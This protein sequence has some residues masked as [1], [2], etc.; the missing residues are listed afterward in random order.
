MRA[1]SFGLEVQVNANTV[2]GGSG[3]TDI[4]I[5]ILAGGVFHSLTQ[6]AFTLHTYNT[7]I[8]MGVT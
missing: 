2:S 1:P 5:Y 8:S 6:S 4:Y 7:A 3:E